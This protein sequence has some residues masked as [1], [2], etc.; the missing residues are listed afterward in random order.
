MYVVLV[1]FTAHPGQASAFLAAVRLQAKNSLTREDQCRRFDVCTDPENP[2]SV[3]LYE[4]YDSRAAFDAHLAS[5]HMAEFNATVD[6]MVAS[7]TV[8]F[9]TLDEG[10]EP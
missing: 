10:A 1:E 3:V 2:A 7:K 8:R 6:N 5:A 9:L 4:I